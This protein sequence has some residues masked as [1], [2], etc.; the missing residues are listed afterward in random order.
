MN[1][2]SYHCK[3]IHTPFTAVSFSRKENKWICTYFSISV[4]GKKG[5]NMC[6]ALKDKDN[7]GFNLT[8]L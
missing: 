1:K 5:T 2:Q 3:I 7:I 8:Y 4:S 6:Y